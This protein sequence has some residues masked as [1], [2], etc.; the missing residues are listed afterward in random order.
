MQASGV[1]PKR[2][3]M[4]A[5]TGAVVPS[6]GSSFSPVHGPGLPLGQRL[7]EEVAP[8]SVGAYWKRYSAH[9]TSE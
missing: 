3:G 2:S 4:H 6:S 9:A 1:S 8:R 7:A 5:G